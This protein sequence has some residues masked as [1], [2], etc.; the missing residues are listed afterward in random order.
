MRTCCVLISQTRP[1]VEDELRV[2][3]LQAA[4]HLYQPAVSDDGRGTHAVHP[5]TGQQQGGLDSTSSR[6]AEKTQK[7]TIVKHSSSDVS[8]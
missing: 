1:R 2:G 4:G 3:Y 8:H 5:L 6:Q 7:S